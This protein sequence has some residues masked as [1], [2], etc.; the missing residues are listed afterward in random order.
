M[1]YHTFHSIASPIHAL[2]PLGYRNTT[3]SNRHDLTHLPC[4]HESHSSIR[5]TQIPKYKA[6]RSV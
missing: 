5:S 2:D 3:G 6:K 4:D 1:T